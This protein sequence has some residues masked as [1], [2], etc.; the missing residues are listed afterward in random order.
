MSH[1]DQA[2]NAVQVAIGYTFTHDELLLEALDTTGMR[3]NESNQRLAMLGAALLTMILLDSWCAGG[4]AKDSLLTKE[5][6]T[7]A[8]VP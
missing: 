3:T 7:S 6:S 8:V 5:Y 1:K 2:C 4:T